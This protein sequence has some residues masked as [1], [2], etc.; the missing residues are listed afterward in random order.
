MF[1]TDGEVIGVNAAIFTARG[2]SGVGF[3]LPSNIA[4]WVSGQLITNGKVRRGW[5]GITVSTVL[6]DTQ[7]KPGICYYRNQ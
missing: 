1:N 5:L 6:T 3:S 7:D 2:A 4:N